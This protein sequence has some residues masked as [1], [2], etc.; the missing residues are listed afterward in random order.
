[1]INH[2]GDLDAISKKYNIKKDTLI[3]FSGNIGPLCI[4]EDIKN[5][6]INN[7]DAI[8]TY[9]DKTY[10]NLKN[11][12]C[13]YCLC[14]K[15]DINVGNGATELISLFIKAYNPKKALI[16]SPSYLEYEKELKNI[17][18][19]ISFFP[20]KE[21]EDFIP[22][23]DLLIK[24]LKDIEL[25][26]ICNPNNPT[27]YSIKNNDI[28]RILD[29]C[30]FL[31]VDETYA[32]FENNSCIPLTKEYQNLFVI[33]GTSKF[34]GV[35]GIRLGYCICKNKEINDKILKLKDLWSVNSFA[36]IIGIH[37]FNNKDFIY[38]TKHIINTQKQMFYSELSNIKTIKLYK[39]N[40]NFILC[41]IL[42]KSINSSM[43]FEKLIK[44][45]IIIRDAK[46]FALLNDKF[47][48]FCILEED[49]NKILI[50]ELKNIFE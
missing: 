26:I 46:D 34:F 16:L 24:S 15:E 12:I 20:L 49:N 27:G 41:K 8:K 35:P 10:E 48:R 18:C 44:Q 37:L 31:M 47:F 25:V 2:G 7:I 1:M 23:I 33:R 22:N 5:I 9:P 43:L 3:D 4:S 28:K 17:N 14:D 45:N 42:D 13:S 50:K 39:S 30:K 29:N 6:I 32:E 40:S 38:K 11:A 21:E 36:N 19:K